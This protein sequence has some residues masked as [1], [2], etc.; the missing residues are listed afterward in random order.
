M[1]LVLGTTHTPIIH[2]PIII[3]AFLNF[4]FSPTNI[5]FSSEIIKS[6]YIKPISVPCTTFYDSLHP[7]TSEPNRSSPFIRSSLFL[8]ST[9]TYYVADY[10]GHLRCWFRSPPVFL[11]DLLTSS[12][13]FLHPSKFGVDSSRCFVP[14]PAP[15]INSAC[16]SFR[17]SWQ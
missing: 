15:C 11:L 10:Q 16:P 6:T 8:H 7:P 3:S 2:T 5:H 13:F 4:T 1:V 12:F 17:I 9:A 14:T